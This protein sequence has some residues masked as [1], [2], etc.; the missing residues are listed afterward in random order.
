MEF[1]T[2]A[3]LLNLNL[4]CYYGD[5]YTLNVL[6]VDSTTFSCVPFYDVLHWYFQDLIFVLNLQMSFDS[7]DQSIAL[8]TTVLP[9]FSVYRSSCI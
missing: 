5:K 3:I 8:L 9:C 1:R 6:V 7:L 4:P 2:F